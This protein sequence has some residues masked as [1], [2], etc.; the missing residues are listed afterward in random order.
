MKRKPKINRKSVIKYLRSF[1]QIREE[2]AT[3]FH[4]KEA[5]LEKFMFWQ[6]I[7]LEFFYMDGECVGIRARDYEDRKKFPLIHDMELENGERL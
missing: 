6:G 5:E 2:Y 1:W 7:P 4:K 3:E